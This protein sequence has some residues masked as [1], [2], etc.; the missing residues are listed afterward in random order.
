MKNAVKS[1]WRLPFKEQ[2]RQETPLVKAKHLPYREFSYLFNHRHILSACRVSRLCPVFGNGLTFVRQTFTSGKNF[3]NQNHNTFQ[4]FKWS[5]FS[6]TT[7]PQPSINEFLLSFFP[8]PVQKNL[9]TTNLIFSFSFI[10]RMPAIKWNSCC[11]GWFR[12]LLEVFGTKIIPMWTRFENVCYLT[13]S[14]MPTMMI[15]STVYSIVN[16][17]SF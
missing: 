5:V 7:Q 12:V 6:S 3:L 13:N 4:F 10:K 11:Y 17:K 16:I 15:E 9:K 1:Y 2:L 8:F 14:V